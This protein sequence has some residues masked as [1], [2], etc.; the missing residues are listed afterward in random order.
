M[1]N[2]M[3]CAV[4]SPLTLPMICSICIRWNV[5]WAVGCRARTPR[6]V[7]RPQANLVF[8]I[9]FSFFREIQLRGQRVR[10]GF[11]FDLISEAAPCQS[12]SSTEKVTKLLPGSACEEVARKKV[13]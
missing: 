12:E 10:A 2:W 13:G 7:I 11:K 9:G 5:A 4:V 1:R 6:R 8:M 3:A